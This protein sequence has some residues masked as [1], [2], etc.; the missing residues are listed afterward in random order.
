MFARSG[1]HPEATPSRSQRY[2]G[3]VSRS[4]GLS[5]SA[6]NDLPGDAQGNDDGGCVNSPRM[7]LSLRVQGEGSIVAGGMNFRRLSKELRGGI[8]LL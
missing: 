5:Y 6:F 4:G 7:L 8:S 1:G 2:R 3:R